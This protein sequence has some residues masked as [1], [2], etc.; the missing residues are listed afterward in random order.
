[1]LRSWA[2]LM[3]I[4]A[5]CATESVDV[6]APSCVACVAH[7]RAPDP[8]DDDRD[9][10]TRLDGPER[11]EVGA[12]ARLSV[13]PDDAWR[14]LWRCVASGRF[15]AL[16]PLLADA[17]DHEL[18]TRR[19]APLLLARVIASRGGNVE[20]DL[21]LLHARRLA[22]FTLSQA[23]ARPDLYRGALVIVRAR[24]SNHG[25]LD[26]TRIVSQSWDVPV[27]PTERLTTQAA[28]PFASSTQRLYTTRRDYNLDVETG[29]RVMAAID[30][31]PFIDADDPLVVLG[32][33]EGLRDADGWPL[34]T[35]LDHF[36]PNA[37]IAY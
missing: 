36:R 24:L 23:L 32:R 13:A 5:G 19:D 20:S 22:L 1:M 11:C 21:Q 27:S 17:W 18:R 35:V 2:Y 15:T 9:A 6:E 10:A 7:G 12:R 26:E 14:E 30:G 33:F 37:T 29:T 28:A 31:D 4:V 34:V 8:H 3:L 16:R 25:I